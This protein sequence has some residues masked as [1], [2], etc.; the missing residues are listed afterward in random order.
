MAE[1]EKAITTQEELN[2]VIGERLKREKETAEKRYADWTSPEDL[3]KLNEEHAAALKKYED[4]AAE[5]QKILE[6]KDKE[7]AESA[8]YKADLEKTRIALAAGLDAKFADR[9]R[10]ENTE[11][12]TKDAKE[13]AKDFAASHSAPPLGSSEPATLNAKPEEVAQ[14]KFAEWLDQ[15]NSK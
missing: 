5:T 4:A 11:E 12:W 13:L 8:R 9:L 3:Q 1:L 6:E 10:G 15:F 14:R 7:I 2:A